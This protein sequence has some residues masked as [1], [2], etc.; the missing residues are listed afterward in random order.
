VHGIKNGIDSAH[1]WDLQLAQPAAWAE[2]ELLISATHG[3]NLSLRPAFVF[4]P[5]PENCTGRKLR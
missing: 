3:G 5:N 1:N 4:H 2:P